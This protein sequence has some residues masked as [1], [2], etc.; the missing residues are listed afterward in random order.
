VE[1][2]HVHVGLLS[3]YFLPALQPRLLDAKEVGVGYEYGAAYIYTAHSDQPLL[4]NDAS[5]TAW[6]FVQE[7]PSEITKFSLYVLRDGQLAEICTRPAKGF[8]SEETD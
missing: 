3:P 6:D 5:M 1:D 4:R 7:H 2:G 8:Y